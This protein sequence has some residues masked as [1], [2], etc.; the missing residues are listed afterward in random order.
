[1]QAADPARL[2]EL[3]EA[4]MPF[5]KYKGRRLLDL[6]EAYLLWFE[7]QG[8]PQGRLGEQLLEILELKRSGADQV[9]RPLLR[10]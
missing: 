9:L 3:I 8:F 4:R 10:R 5:G 2:L 1:M 7:R 6:P